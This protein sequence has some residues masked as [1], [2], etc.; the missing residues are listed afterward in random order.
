MY[1]YLYKFKKFVIILIEIIAVTE[2][3][4]TLDICLTAKPFYSTKQI[5][6]K[7]TFDQYTFPF[8]NKSVEIIK[9]H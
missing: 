1:R 3:I 6:D 7:N 4:T 8:L 5:V 2:L 9:H